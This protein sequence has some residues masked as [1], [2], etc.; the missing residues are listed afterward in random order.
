MVKICFWS[1]RQG[2][3]Y[4]REERTPQMIITAEMY[5]KTIFHGRGR[6]ETLLWKNFVYT[7]EPSPGIQIKLRDKL[8]SKG[9]DEKEDNTEQ[10]VPLGVKGKNLL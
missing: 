2:E 8:Y 1:G 9:Q 7:D 10:R 4:A 3:K 6:A 5:N